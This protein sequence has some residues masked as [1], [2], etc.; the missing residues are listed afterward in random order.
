MITADTI[1]DEQIRE[2]RIDAADGCGEPWITAY[3]ES[4][5][6]LH[7]QPS[8]S[9]FPTSTRRVVARARCAAILNARAVSP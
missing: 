4:G 1:T 7:D 8:A 3:R 2:L 6:A 5:I 9:D